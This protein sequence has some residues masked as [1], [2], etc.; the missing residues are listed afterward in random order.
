MENI[1]SV[2][3]ATS[4]DS[5]AIL[6]CLRAAFAPY[7]SRYTAKGYEDTTLTTTLLADRLMEMAVFVA[8]AGKDEIVGTIACGDCHLRGMAVLPAALGKGVARLLLEA[9]EAQLR[10]EG[11]Q[12]VTLDTT[13]PLERAMRFYEKHGYRRSGQ[14]TDFF[15]MPLFEYVKAL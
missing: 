15:G 3:R 13:E 9:A 11:C 8:V 14:V 2:R 7:Q 5:E 1:I 10:A 4:R 12:R 6:I